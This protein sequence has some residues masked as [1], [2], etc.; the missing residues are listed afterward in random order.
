M[1]KVPPLKPRRDGMAKGSAV[2]L[3]STPRSMLP[4]RKPI[5]EM[6]RKYMVATDVGGTCTFVLH[7]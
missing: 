2:V 3:I 7:A 1:R 6:T 5:N 4:L